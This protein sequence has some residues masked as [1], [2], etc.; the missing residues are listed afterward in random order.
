MTERAEVQPEGVYLSS[1]D[2]GSVI[3]LETRSRHYR[4][5]YL[6]GDKAWISGH[7][8]LCPTPVLVHL[9]GSTG[10]DVVESGF[11]GQGMH[12]VFE[13]MD[14]HVPITTSEVTGIHIVTH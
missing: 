11:I 10:H 1:L 6:G 7:P 5:E 14:D 13:R 2:E 8:K 12:L 9:Q 3:D 4:I